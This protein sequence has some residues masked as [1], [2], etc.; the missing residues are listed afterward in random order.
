MRKKLNKSNV[1]NSKL[2]TIYI[3]NN[4]CITLDICRLYPRVI[5]KCDQRHQIFPILIAKLQAN[6]LILWLKIAI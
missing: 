1:Y 5:I 6:K 4:V 2:T 3:S